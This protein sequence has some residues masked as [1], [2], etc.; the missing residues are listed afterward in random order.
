[1]RFKTFYSFSLLMIG[2]MLAACGKEPPTS[3]APPTLTNVN[4]QKLQKKSDDI[5]DDLDDDF[6]DKPKKR[7]GPILNPRF[8]DDSTSS[9]TTPSEKRKL[10]GVAR[11]HSQDFAPT[12]NGHPKGPKAE[13]FNGIIN[14]SFPRINQCFANQMD[15]LRSGKNSIQV[16]L[17][18][19][20]SGSVKETNIVAG[21]NNSEVR[22]CVVETLRSLSFPA[23]EGNEVKQIVPFTFV[24][25]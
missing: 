11:P 21:I 16:K 1:M 3:K 4:I 6:D 2:C 17:T 22:S 12:I 15:E 9:K 19:S 8:S 23:Y 5:E 20:N 13:V 7:S 18:I 10:G 25:R 24:R 14:S